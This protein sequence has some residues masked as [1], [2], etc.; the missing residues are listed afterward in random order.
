MIFAL[1]LAAPLVAHA[2]LAPPPP[3]QL[4]VARPDRAARREALRAKV[5]EA[6]SSRIIEALGLD[7]ATGARLG[8]VLARHEATMQ[9]IRAQLRVLRGELAALV[10]SGKASA[11]EVNPRLDK[12]EAL[13]R[14]RQAADGRLIAEARGVLTPEQAARLVLVLPRI[15]RALMR[16]VMGHDHDH[17][18]DHDG[19]GHEG[20]G[21]G[22]RGHGRMGHDPGTGR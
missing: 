8:T 14:E 9:P 3:A 19:R 11:A 18:H 4:K 17:V 22:K 15:D 20:D 2:D 12:L 16:Q 13:Q 21:G 5:Q 7:A 10:Q 6:R 1:T